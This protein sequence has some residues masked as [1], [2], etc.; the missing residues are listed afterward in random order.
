MNGQSRVWGEHRKTNE[1]IWIRQR[2]V[3]PFTPKVKGRQQGEAA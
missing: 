3:L 1:S 2:F